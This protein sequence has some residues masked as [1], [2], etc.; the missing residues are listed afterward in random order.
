VG[1]LGVPFPLIKECLHSGKVIPFLG[2]G[3]S[4]SPGP[5]GLPTASVL[6][7]RL[8]SK[9]R[10]PPD[11]PE[12]LSTVA[13]W[14]QV[15][16][17]RVR[18][19][20]ELHRVF[21]AP[22]VPARLHHYLAEVKAPLLVVTTNYDDLL[23]QAFDLAG[24]EHDRVVHTIGRRFGEQVLWWPHGAEEPQRKHPNKLDLDLSAT[25]VI[26]KM[27][28]AVDRR[29]ASRDQYVIT[30]DDYIDFLTRLTRRRAVPA[31]FAEPFQSRHFL[32][33]GYGLR[34]WNL[35]VVLN[36]IER[37]VSGMH[38]IVSWAIVSEPSPLEQR[39]WQE[40]GVEVYKMT[41]DEF[42]NGLEEG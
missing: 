24:R 20:D 41:V 12:T 11:E 10:F 34:D 25:T 38:R 30:E 6:A 29:L 3:A 19:E 21:A 28:G 33:L 4:W 16:G 15:V 14:F 39:F 8:A 5:E 1:D 27:H 36:G 31:V 32:F 9:T 37:D 17:G 7:T 26:Y 40:R 23:E 2:S 18:L 22:Y 35:R 13:Q 42:L